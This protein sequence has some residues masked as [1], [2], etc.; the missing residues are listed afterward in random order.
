[1]RTSVRVIFVFLNY[2]DL[3]NGFRSNI[4][5]A[6]LLVMGPVIPCQ[7]STLQRVCT[8]WRDFVADFLVEQ[9][10]KLRFACRMILFSQIRTWMFPFQRQCVKMKRVYTMFINRCYHI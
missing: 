5:S 3:N 10:S 4:N 2:N 1:M 7:L 6:Y 9:R 8:A